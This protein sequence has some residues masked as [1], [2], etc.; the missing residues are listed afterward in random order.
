MLISHWA[1]QVFH[2]DLELPWPSYDFE[3]FES[4]LTLS[5]IDCETAQS[6]FILSI[7]R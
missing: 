4:N 6:S 5:Q 7:N 2:V 3:I 1:V